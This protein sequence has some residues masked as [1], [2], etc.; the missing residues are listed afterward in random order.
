M[1]KFTQLAVALLGWSP[2]L[3]AALLG[4]SMLA[5]G[6][7]GATICEGLTD[8][9]ER[10]CRLSHLSERTQAECD[11]FERS[12]AD[13]CGGAEV[14]LIQASAAATGIALDLLRA[15]SRRPGVW[16]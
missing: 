8:A 12:I 11:A 14:D 15:R 7:T 16:G 3:A 6:A 5:G 1:T 13:L 10:Y 9:S 4:S 2:Q